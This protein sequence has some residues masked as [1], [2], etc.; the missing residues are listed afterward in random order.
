MKNRAPAA[1]RARFYKNTYKTNRIL[2]NFEV[3]AVEKS[4]KN[5]SKIDQKSIQNRSKIN[6]KSIPNEAPRA[7][8]PLLATGGAGGVQGGRRAVASSGP[9]A[10]R[11]PAP[12]PAPPLLAG[13]QNRAKRCE[14]CS[15]WRVGEVMRKDARAREER[16]PRPLRISSKHQRTSLH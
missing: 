6:P 12:P 3:R 7:V 4:I 5:Q 9:T 14:G 10:R 13:P 1:G 8:G 15:K 11:P 2:M 16:T